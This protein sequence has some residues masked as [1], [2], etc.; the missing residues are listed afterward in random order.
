M[1]KTGSDKG[2]ER[3]PERTIRRKSNCYWA[4]K[5]PYL[6]GEMEKVGKK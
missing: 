5:G 2:L 4:Y 6:I 1:W 3:S